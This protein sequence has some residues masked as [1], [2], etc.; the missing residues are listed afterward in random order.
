MALTPREVEKMLDGV[1]WSK[2]K[3][4]TKPL[5]SGWISERSKGNS[6]QKCWIEVWSTPIFLLC[7]YEND[8]LNEIK[9]PGPRSGATSIFPLGEIESV[10]MNSETEG[11]FS[12]HFFE[13]DGDGH[14][15]IDVRTDADLSQAAI[16]TETLNVLSDEHRE[17]EIALEMENS[18]KLGD[19]SSAVVTTKVATKESKHDSDS[20][21]KKK[22]KEKKNTGGCSPTDYKRYRSQLVAFY[23][24]HGLDKKVAVVDRLLAMYKGNEKQLLSDV[25]AKYGEPPEKKVLRK[26]KSKLSPRKSKIKKLEESYVKE[27]KK[28]ESSAGY[29]KLKVNDNERH[30][31]ST[32]DTNKKA[33][34]LFGSPIIEKIDQNETEKKDGCDDAE[35]K[36]VYGEHLKREKDKNDKSGYNEDFERE[37]TIDVPRSASGEAHDLFASPPQSPSVVL[38]KN[39]AV[40]PRNQRKD[41][42]LAAANKA[43]RMSEANEGKNRDS[44]KK[45]EDED[46]ANESK[47]RD[48]EKEVEDED[49]ANEGKNR[50]S[51]KEI[52]DEDGANESKNRDSDKEVEDEDGANEGKNRDSEK[53]IEDEDG[54]N[55]SKN[56]DSDKEV[57]DEDGA[58]EGKNRDSE[59][60]IEDE[61]GA[62]ESKNRD[63]DK[64]VEDEDGANEGKNRDS[65][66][67]AEDE[68]GDENGDKE[69][70]NEEVLSSGANLI[71]Q[72]LQ[73]RREERERRKREGREEGERWTK[74]KEKERDDN[75]RKERESKEEQERLEF[76]RLR[77]EE[78]EEEERQERRRLK[79]EEEEQESLRVTQEEEEQERLHSKEVEED[80]ADKTEVNYND[81]EE[82][83]EGTKLNE[84]EDNLEDVALDD[85]DE[86]EVLY[87]VDKED[88]VDKK[89]E[90]P[91]PKLSEL[92]DDTNLNVGTPLQIIVKD[93]PAKGTWVD[94]DLARTR[95][96]GKIDV[97]IGNLTGV[98]STFSGKLVKKVKRCDLRFSPKHSP[99]ASSRFRKLKNGDGV[100]SPG[101]V[102]RKALRF[103]EE[104]RK[105]SPLAKSK[106]DETRLNRKIVVGSEVYVDDID[107][108]GKKTGKVKKAVV[109]EL[110][111][112]GDIAVRY[113]DESEEEEVRRC[114]I[115]LANDEANTFSRCEG[116]LLKHFPGHYFKWFPRKVVLENGALELHIQSKQRKKIAATEMAD[117]IVEMNNT[118]SCMEC[119]KE[120]VSAKFLSQHIYRRHRGMTAEMAEKAAAK[121]GDTGV[122]S[123]PLA[124]IGL[125]NCVNVR[126]CGANDDTTDFELRFEYFNDDDKAMQHMLRFRASSVEE[127]KK[128]VADIEDN[129]TTWKSVEKQYKA[130]NETLPVH[131]PKP[132][133]L[134]E[135]SRVTSVTAK[136]E[137]KES[138]DRVLESMQRRVATSLADG[139]REAGDDCASGV[140]M[141]VELLWELHDHIDECFRREEHAT[142]L[143]YLEGY[144]S[145][146]VASVAHWLLSVDEDLGPNAILRLLDFI[147]AHDKVVKYGSSIGS[148]GIGRDEDAATPRTS[149]IAPNAVQTMVG[150][151]SPLVQ[152][153]CIDVRKTLFS[154][155]NQAMKDFSTFPAEHNE[156][157][158]FLETQFPE[159]FFDLVDVHVKMV[160]PIKL[161]ALHRAVATLIGDCCMHYTKLF[162]DV[163]HE[164]LNRA[165]ATGT[166]C[167]NGFRKSLS[168]AEFEE[169]FTSGESSRMIHSKDVER[170]ICGCNDL[171][172]C[173]K[174][175]EKLSEKTDFFEK[176][177]SRKKESEKKRKHKKKG[178]EEERLPLDIALNAFIRLRRKAVEALPRIQVAVLLQE[179][180]PYFCEVLTAEHIRLEDPVEVCE[181]ICG[182][183][184]RRVVTFAGSVPLRLSVELIK[185]LFSLVGRVYLLR[186]KSNWKGAG[187]LTSLFRARFQMPPSTC[188]IFKT[189]ISML[190]HSFL[191]S[192]RVVEGTGKRSSS[193]DSSDDYEASLERKVKKFWTQS[194]ELLW[195][196]NALQLF[197]AGNFGL[198]EIP[199]KFDLKALELTITD[200]MKLCDGTGKK[201]RGTTVEGFMFCD[202]IFCLRT[203]LSLNP[204]LELEVREHTAS[205]VKRKDVI[206][207]AGEKTRSTMVTEH[208]D[209]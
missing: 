106:K 113:D 157:T 207:A 93:G 148:A 117:E 143:L 152:K 76:E 64:E 25:K 133:W 134:R 96:S 11:I 163:M 46:G 198:R 118:W 70:D 85:D 192:L 19:D 201:R 95:S 169:Y 79:E 144:S 59:K 7:F 170:I 50:D 32:G 196:S 24:G 110:C 84:G 17:F 49:G 114:E 177:F 55:E 68:D 149:H 165:E 112:D 69:I 53:E 34:E 164:I 89:D 173:E 154:V 75:E 21:R 99:H 190:R 1:D 62:N 186:M 13:D 129:I 78:E 63:S 208:W 138:I 171:M 22:N 122:A 193:T 142:A 119:G 145:R 187:G 52:E 47:N 188:K 58:N 40:K 103:R 12:I 135:C 90:E 159:T 204:E 30:R 31:S 105:S 38:N 120:F 36:N 80:K 137:R 5:L 168:S 203:D 61:D 194:S 44:E 77:R 33:N 156:S 115:T 132:F 87:E 27:R 209:C 60:E 86:E 111:E 91:I 121:E 184:E 197:Q 66:K 205:Q 81:E 72:K 123:D 26:S 150:D 202:M 57:E 3:D 10:R 97:Q 161:P 162:S 172:R 102:Q 9:R 100:R 141:S 15:L 175:C 158:N 14:D 37:N 176:V 166:F 146:I 41:A 199:E 83:A 48:S 2:Y 206:D 20:V 109:V 16:W 130:K 126:K 189:D 71:R 125:L 180:Y 82:E 28:L 131:P 124:R 56:R 127:R 195:L 153:F 73:K 42:M 6:W 185:C 155:I 200:V 67:E 179:A 182:L 147:V 4:H 45:S 35:K 54:A 108:D 94:C 116:I 167:V 140:M 8:T 107:D 74:N 43:Q 65:E 39:P 92:S 136:R 101:E 174:R 29:E 181:A 191:E 104:V 88:E 183:V 178:E 160:R 51:E 98:L 151:V 23:K 139:A 128:W 18:G